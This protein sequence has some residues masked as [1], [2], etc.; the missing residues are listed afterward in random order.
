VRPRDL[1]DPIMESGLVRFVL[2]GGF[3]GAGKTT[4]IAR[5]ARMF[6]DRGLE[7]GIITN[8]QADELVDTGTL[9]QGG[10]AVEQ[11]AGAC[12]CCDF[13]GLI[14]SA[15]ALV[16]RKQPRVILAEPVGSCTDLVATVVR[17]LMK[18]FQADFE[19]AP[20]GVLLKPEYARLIL[21]GDDATLRSD[22]AYIFRKQ[23][24]EADYIAINKA[25]VLGEDERTRLLRF[26]EEINPQAPVV[27]VSARTGQGFDE[28]LE[29][30]DGPDGVARRI[31]DVDYD[32]YAR[33]EAELGWL[34]SRVL[35][36]GPD[37]FP[38]DDLLREI[39]SRLAG[40]LEA[41]EA[42][43]AHLKISARSGSLYGVVNQVDGRA[44]E[45]SIASGGEAREAALTVNARVAIDPAILEEEVATALGRA[46][47]SRGLHHEIPASRS[48]RPGRPV[49]VHRL[50]S[51]GD[52]ID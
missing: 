5:L 1:E 23:L 15:E 52:L 36:S 35:V 49:P 24:E 46:C 7:V 9:A 42:E 30:I 29:L 12:F 51:V 11:V 4:A 27:L 38:L 39:A 47:S 43:V 50:I 37:P 33:G 41:R 34:N 45:L 3:L 48:L 31:M 19:L 44:G 21:D 17:P 10:F 16:A 6:E 32:R 28:L 25:D 26:A 2:L 14:R 18:L 20:Y 40:A 8:D 13:H 22:A